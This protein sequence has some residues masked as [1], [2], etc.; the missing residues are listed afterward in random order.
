MFRSVKSAS[1]WEKQ[2]IPQCLAVKNIKYNQGSKEQL[3]GLIK[4]YQIKV[5]Q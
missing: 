5:V 3:H 4:C 2:L 1:V